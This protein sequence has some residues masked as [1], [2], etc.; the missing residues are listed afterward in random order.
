MDGLT[1]AQW[2][3][4]RM[5]PAGYSQTNGIDF[6]K[7][8]HLPR[9]S[10]ATMS[11]SDVENFIVQLVTATNRE[12]FLENSIGAIARDHALHIAV[13]RQWVADKEAIGS[14]IGPAFW[15]W[16]KKSTIEAAA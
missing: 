3:Y 16:A 4:D 5:T 7:E 13:A 15:A 12:V 14:I 9:F 11:D 2:K 6:D 8:L 10:A 1:S